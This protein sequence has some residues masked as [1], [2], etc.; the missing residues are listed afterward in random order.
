[1]YF[2]RLIRLGVSVFHL[3]TNRSRPLIPPPPYLSLTIPT[4]KT[5]YLYKTLIIITVVLRY[6][7]DF[8]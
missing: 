1:M 7:D 3:N 5:L 2:I 4:E 6:L 8:W